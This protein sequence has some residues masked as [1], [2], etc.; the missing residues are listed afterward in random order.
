MATSFRKN[1]KCGVDTYYKVHGNS[2]TNPHTNIINDIVKS[3]S[4]DKNS[5]IL[6]LACG[7]GE[8]TMAL[9][10]IGCT[11]I[12]G[13]DPYTHDL[14]H[15]NTRLVAKSCT[16]EDIACKNVLEGCNYD[17]IICSF[18]MHLCPKEYLS[19]LCLNLALVSK[20]LVV[21]SPHKQ[22]VVPTQYWTLVNQY[23][24]ERVHV[25]LFIRTTNFQNIK[26]GNFI[27]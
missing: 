18:A 12:Q 8:V 15:K 2:Y 27:L 21:I 10:S 9:Q 20:M 1:Y 22:P 3:L 17:V 14:Y 23:T 5:K 24:R 7:G 6:D 26:L 19:L 25:R 11:N 13:I 4:I 16:F